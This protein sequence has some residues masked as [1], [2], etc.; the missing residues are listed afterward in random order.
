MTESTPRPDAP[1]L[2]RNLP[3]LTVPFAGLFVISGACGLTYE[4]VWSRMLAEVFGVT[5]FAVST[6]LVSYMGG[7]ALGAALLGRRADTAKRP[8]RMFALLEAGVGTYA[9]LLPLLLRLVDAIY[10]SV[11]PLLPESFLLRSTIRFV[12][13]IALLLV[14]TALMGATLPAL[15]Q[16]LLRRKGQVGLGVGFLYFVNTA[17]AAVGCFLAGWWL[18]PYLGL[19]RT[20]LLAACF[21]AVVATTAWLLDRRSTGAPAD[22]EAGKEEEEAPAGTPLTDPASWPLW[23]AFGSGMAALAFEVVWF[24]VLVLVFGSTVYSFSAMLS[25]FL[26]G[27]AAGAV[28]VGRLADRFE[29]PV[30]LLA[31]TQGAVALFVLLGS[32]A[33]NAMPGLFLRIIWAAGITFEGMNET[34]LLLSV[35]TLIPAGLA[36]GGTFPVV[37]RLAAA[38]AGG[39]GSRIGRVYAWNTVG[40]ILG[41]FGAGFVLLPTIGCEWTLKLVVAISLVLAFGS[42]LAEP[43]PVRPKWAIPAGLAVVVLAGVLLF[44]PRWDRKL[45]GAGAYFEPRTFLSENGGVLVDRIVADY[46]LMTYTEGYNETIISFRSAKGKFITVNGST[47]ASD[48][49]DDMFSQRMLGHLPMLMHPGPVRKACVVGL[50]AGVTAGAIGLHEVDRLTGIE[51]E[52]GVFEASRF[53]ADVNHHLLEN[54]KLDVRI[55]DGRNFLKLTSDR[56]DVIS[57]APNFPSLT[58]SGAL[59][60]RDYFEL[61]RARLAPSGVMCQFVPVW[62]ILPGD[63][64]TIVGSFADVFP[65]VRLFSTGLSLVLLGREEPFPPVDVVELTRRVERPEVK[66]SLAGIGVRG[67]VE[68]LSFYQADEAEIRKLASGAPRSSDDRPRV[69]FFA[70]RGLFADTVGPNL[71]ELMRLRPSAEER[72][73]RLGL[74]GEY[75][76][77]FLALAGAYQAVIDAQI[78]RSVGKVDDAMSVALPSAESGQ[79]YARFLVADWAF[80]AGLALQQRGDL[81]AA[82]EEFAL[83]AHEEPDNLDAL[84]N[85][86][87]VDLFLGKADEAEKVLVH[88]V[89]LYPESAGAL[90]RL[91]ILRDAQGKSDEAEALYRRAIAIEPILS[92]PHALL[93]SRLLARGRA[94]EALFEIEEAI[95]LGERTEGVLAAWAEALLALARPKEALGRAREAVQLFPGSPDLFDVL[96]KAAG[97]AGAKE[98]AASAEKRRDELIRGRRPALGLSVP[99]P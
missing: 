63:M 56:F 86:G 24:R 21:N 75:R 72:A 6:V 91:G 25:V 95:R 14:P 60:S 81:E 73:A 19:F 47:T 17:G 12:L 13:C 45:L 66:A 26:L 23:V 59:Y 58:G 35:L 3:P 10:A 38:G 84:V 85:L 82:R 51:L 41:S 77:S 2:L 89:E 69:E 67:P 28:I 93:G 1:G 64:K 80:K 20:T 5:A 16:G 99:T 53:F 7:M 32:L 9:L 97:A 30:R 65:R 44:A 55:D 87:Y 61:C 52:K 76:S 27:I 88:A 42:L 33:V 54:P 40:S 78:L 18:L 98:E 68:V 50:G 96:A 22:E 48:H 39:T 11:F 57:S 8:L 4:V 94:A 90:H 71:R 29:P 36:F 34:K 62:R 70:P 43:G 92:G 31:L 74:D 49:F 46:K 37:V 79:R 15:G 83:A